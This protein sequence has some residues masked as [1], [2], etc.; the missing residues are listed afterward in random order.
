MQI[1]SLRAQFVRNLSDVQIDPGPGINVFTGPNGSGKT[2]MLEAIYSLSRARSFRTSRINEVI[3]HSK[4]ELSVSA[5]IASASGVPADISINKAHG[6]TNLK[7]CGESVHK[8]SEQAKNFPLI[9]MVPDSHILITGGPKQRRHWIDWFMFHV[10]PLYLEG[11]RQYHQALRQRNTLLKQQSVNHEEIQGWELS[12]EKY[13]THLTQSR[14][15]VIQLVNNEL[16]RLVI[17]I[18]PFPVRLEFIQG[19]VFEQGLSVCLQEE[20][21]KDIQAGRTKFGAHRADIQFFTDDK[22][23][24]AVCSRGQIKLFIALLLIAQ[25]RVIEQV[26]NEKPVY[27]IDEY[28]GELDQQVRNKFI[29]LLIEQKSQV[30]LTSTEINKEISHQTEIKTFHV[31]HGDYKKM[32]E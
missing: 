28:A 27:L 22:P 18:L 25:A 19:W 4:R 1:K 21:S 14:N 30:F 3:Q 26:I 17:D 24:V 16:E 32:V 2:A 5:K 7:Y 12:M 11:W 10:E 9:L 8:V 29:S 31:E 20:R 6:K 23:V 13:A 15:R